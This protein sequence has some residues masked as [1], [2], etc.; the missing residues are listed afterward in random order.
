[1]T[2]PEVPL[3]VTSPSGATSTSVTSKL[4]WLFTVR[5]ISPVPPGSSL[6]LTVPVAVARVTFFRVVTL[7]EPLPLPELVK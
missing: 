7:A 3:A 4:F 2:Q 5:V 6:A 1:M